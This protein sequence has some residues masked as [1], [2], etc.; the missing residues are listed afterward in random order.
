[1]LQPTDKAD[2]LTVVAV[3][4]VVGVDVVRVEVQ[5]PRVVRAVGRRRPIVAVVAN[6][7]DIR[8][9]AVTGSGKE[10][11]QFIERPLCYSRQKEL[12]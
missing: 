1:M 9:V 3:V 2:R 8:T 12:F 4:V 5:V 10:H 6:I 11:R 7:V